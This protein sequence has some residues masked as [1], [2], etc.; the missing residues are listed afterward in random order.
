A[1]RAPRPPRFAVRLGRE[2]DQ[3]QGVIGSRL[4]LG[5]IPHGDNEVL[6]NTL[7]P[8]GFRDGVF[9]DHVVDAVVADA[10]DIAAAGGEDAVVQSEFGV[11]AVDDIESVGFDR[12]FQDGAFVAVPAAFA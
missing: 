11:T 9:F 6:G 8:G 7:G 5:A 12:A 3:T 2:R 4:L 10:T 1:A